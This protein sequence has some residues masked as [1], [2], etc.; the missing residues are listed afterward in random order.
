MGSRWIEGLV[1]A[2]SVESAEK[3]GH[4]SL[5]QWEYKVPAGRL[6]AGMKMGSIL[7]DC[8][9]ERTPNLHLPL[10]EVVHPIWIGSLISQQVARG[11][12]YVTRRPSFLLTRRIL[13]NLVRGHD[14]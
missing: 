2:L 12:D 10:H 8:V 9:G 3:L 4:R 11:R 5:G 1:R 13:E 14:D 7:Q 6:G